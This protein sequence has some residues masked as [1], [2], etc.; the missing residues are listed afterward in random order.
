MRT[1]ALINMPFSSI[2]RPSIGLG[3]LKSAVVRDGHQAKIHNFNL[4]FA[5]MVGVDAYSELANIPSSLIGEWIFAR[6]LNG[7]SDSDE[8]FFRGFPPGS[9]E[10]MR[11]G[12]LKMRDAVEPFLERC[13]AADDWGRYDIVG[14]TSV[15]EQTMASL[16]LAKRV[17]SI[18]PRALIALG[19]ANA[20]GPMGLALLKAY[21]VIDVVCSGEGDIAFPAFVEALEAG[22]DRA[23]PGILR[24]GVDTV[25]SAAAS[26]QDMDLLPEP[27]YSDFFEQFVATSFGAQEIANTNVPFESSRGCWWGEK[28]HCKFCGLNGQSMAFR[29]KSADRAL[30]ELLSLRTRYQDYTEKF[31]AVDNILDYKYFKSLIPEIRDRNLHLD[32]FYETKSNLSLDQ[33]KLLRSANITKIQPGI[34]SLSTAVLRLMGKGVSALQNVQLLKFCKQLGIQP[35]WNVLYGFPGEDPTEYDRLAQMMPALGHLDPPANWFQIRLDRFSPYFKRSAQHGIVNVRP[36][37][38]YDIIHERVS[39][40]LRSDMA[41]YFD[42]NYADERNPH[43]YV[44]AFGTALQRWIAQS[45]QQ[46]LFYEVV[47]ETLYIFDHRDSFTR[48]LIALRGLDRAIYEKLDRVCGF[49]NLA[50][51]LAGEGH[52]VEDGYLRARLARLEARGLLIAES[53]L[54]LGVALPLGDYD[55]PEHI[56]LAFRGAVAKATAYEGASAREKLA[57]TA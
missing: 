21:P 38:Q 15:F 9:A 56:D 1:I 22:V 13:L 19:G 45:G 33:V 50:K 53:D 12:I 18:A 40:E 29:S 49:A 23:I 32:L 3:L 17:K 35:L 41:Y 11:D 44:G 31:Y 36:F 8:R 5:D 14:F 6:A 10:R 54:F 42:F 7:A 52:Q 47:D 27:D 55:P 16:A 4:L 48:G 28:S 34:E 20:E 24:Q 46:Y 51:S 37:R 2:Y 26:V 30:S 43:N 25:A 57:A 39:P